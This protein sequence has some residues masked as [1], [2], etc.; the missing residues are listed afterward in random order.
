MKLTFLGTSCMVP[1]RDRSHAAAFLELEPYGILIDCGE[2]TQRQF[3]LADIRPTRITHILLSHWHGDHVLGLPGLLQTMSS[4]NPGQKITLVGPKGTKK[5]LEYMKK[6]FL[7]EPA[8]KLEVIEIMK[9]TPIKNSIMRVD[10]FELDHGI[11]TIGFRISTKDVLHIDTNKVK[12]LGLVDGPWM[13][14]VLSGKAAK[15]GGKTIKPEQVTY[16][17]QGKIIG[18]VSDTLMCTSCADIARDADLLVCEAAY[19]SNLEEKAIEYKHMTSAQAAQLAS[20]ENVEKLIINHFSQRYK[21]VDELL[22]EAKDIF[23]NT[24]AAF[25][26]MKVKI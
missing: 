2:G 8:L 25:D 12:K 16:V 4:M 6:A 22:N 17:E 18:L 10:V 20:R 21:M 9:G 11:P 14:Q 19:H 13:K 5:Q 23:P 3:K 1:T 15:V 24:D 7:F 26:L